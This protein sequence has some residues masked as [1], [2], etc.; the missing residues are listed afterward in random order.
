[1]LEQA[2]EL[3][4][5]HHLGIIELAIFGKKGRGEGSVGRTILDDL[6]VHVHAIVV[7]V[8]GEGVE[9]GNK[10]IGGG[11][12]SKNFGVEIRSIDEHDLGSKKSSRKKDLIVIG[13]QQVLLAAQ[14]LRVELQFEVDAESEQQQEGKGDQVEKAMLSNEFVGRV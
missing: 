9:H 5:E 1:L 8:A 4:L 11:G 12:R 3:A 14:V 6:R 10:N 13:I 2:G 7:V